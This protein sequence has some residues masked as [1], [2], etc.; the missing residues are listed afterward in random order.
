M[1]TRRT[2]APTSIRWSRPR[3]RSTWTRHSSNAGRRLF[4]V[5]CSGCHG[6]Y[7]GADEAASYPNLLIP[8][9]VV[10]T[11]PTLVEQA[12]SEAGLSYTDWFNRS[13]YGREGLA[14]AGPG[15]VPPPLDGIWATAPYGHNGSVPNLRTWLDST[16]RPTYWR[17]I[18]ETSDDPADFD[19]ADVGWRFDVLESGQ[20]AEPDPARRVRIYDT[21][22]LGHDNGGHRFGD[23]LTDDERTAVVEY[24]KTL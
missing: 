15:Y 23:A 1:P 19:A 10:G 21:T 13:W 14:A 12:Y 8:L 20:D 9:E 22:L 17:R 11:D 6:R 5:N 2:C 7:G 4:D 18:A 16:A 24:L 3:G